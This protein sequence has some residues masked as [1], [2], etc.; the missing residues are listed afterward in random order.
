[1]QR[2]FLHGRRVSEG[3]RNNVPRV[4]TGIADYFEA[5]L[6]GSP[7]MVRKENAAERPPELGGYVAQD[8]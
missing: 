4:L 6:C 5:V 1:M 7:A 2:T 8:D 3:A